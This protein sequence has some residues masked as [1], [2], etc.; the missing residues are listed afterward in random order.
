MA[1][2]EAVRLRLG[3]VEA[4]AERMGREVAVKAFGE[5]GPGLDVSLADLEGLFDK[6]VKGFA[7]GA[8]AEAVARQAQQ[9]PERAECPECGSECARRR[10]P[11]ARPMQTVHGG[12]VWQEPQHF[13]PRC[14]R[15]FFPAT[16]GAA[17]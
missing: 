7:Q 14:T 16:T 11:R 5:Q 9:V 12:F 10:P 4:L 3:E 15:L 6:F 2:T 1:L 8:Y 17:D 13:C